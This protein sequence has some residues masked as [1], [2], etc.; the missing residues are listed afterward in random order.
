MGSCFVKEGLEEVA[1]IGI[2]A[3]GRPDHTLSFCNGPSIVIGTRE[4]SSLLVCEEMVIYK[5]GFLNIKNT[6]TSHP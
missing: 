6:G 5:I 4:T 2:L 3:L 1:A